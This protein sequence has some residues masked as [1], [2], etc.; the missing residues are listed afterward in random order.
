MNSK[1]IAFG[2]R[3]TAKW[4]LAVA[5]IITSGKREQ[6]Q[7]WMQAWYEGWF[8]LQPGTGA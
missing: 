3:F 7:V 1:V 8:A 6:S 2:M 4:Y 5:S